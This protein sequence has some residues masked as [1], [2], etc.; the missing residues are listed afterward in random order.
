MTTNSKRKVRVAS[1]EEWEKIKARHPGPYTWIT[2]IVEV[3]RINLAT[4]ET[5]Y[6]Q[7]PDEETRSAA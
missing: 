4:G 5:E 3:R 6:V 7:A 2:E 1:I